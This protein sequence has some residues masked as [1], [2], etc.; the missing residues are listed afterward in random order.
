M[1]D[2]DIG[3]EARWSAEGY[4]QWAEIDLGATY[5]LSKFEL[6]TFQSRAYQYNIEVK[7]EGGSFAHVVDRTSNTQGGLITDEATATGR[8]VRINV[9]GASGYTGQWISLNELMVYGVQNSSARVAFSEKEGIEL[10]SV[11]KPLIYPNPVSYTDLNIVMPVELNIENLL[12]Y[13]MHGQEVYRQ[14][15]LGMTEIKVSRDVFAKGGI[16]LIRFD[17]QFPYKILVE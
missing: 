11:K 7:P 5:D 4:P 2:G 3:D 17:R 14:K 16:Y 1:V 6:Y 8:Y 15:I 10:E 9:T 13:N 12:I